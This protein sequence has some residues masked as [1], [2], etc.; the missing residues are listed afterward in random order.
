MNLAR[1]QG[2]DDGSLVSLD[3][4]GDLVQVTVARGKIEP[5]AVIMSDK[6]FASFMAG[7]AGQVARRPQRRPRAR[8]HALWPPIIP[9]LGSQRRPA[10]R[11]CEFRHLA[12]RINAL[13]G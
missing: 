2:R 6:E 9:I 12:H 11:L 7:A 4:F 3:V 1:W 10:M 13:A 5:V 8:T